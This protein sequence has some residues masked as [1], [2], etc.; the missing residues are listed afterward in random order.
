MC[1]GILEH[2][3]TEGVQHSQQDESPRETDRMEDMQEKLYSTS[4]K[5]RRTSLRP[6][7]YSSSEE[8][9]SAWKADESN[10]RPM[11]KPKRPGLGLRIFFGASVAFFF[12]AASVAAYIMFGGGNRVSSD[13][14]DIVATGAPAV[15]GGDETSISVKITNNNKV[16]LKE[17]NVVMTYP[18]GFHVKDLEGK[19]V[20]HE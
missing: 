15:A 9:P 18:A 16:A 13:R 4:F 12:V 19:D 10:T 1:F 2:M 14:I 6:S 7:F 3:E 17:V 11:K 5:R 20:S 8:L